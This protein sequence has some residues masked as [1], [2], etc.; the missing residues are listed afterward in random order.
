MAGEGGGICAVGVGE[1][2][3]D[4]D[5]AG[6]EGGDAGEPAVGVRVGGVGG[7]AGFADEVDSLLGGVVGHAELDGVL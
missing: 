4:D 5:G 2:D 6:V 1:V 3:D 7:G